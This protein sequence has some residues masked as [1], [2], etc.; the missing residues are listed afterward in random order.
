MKLRHVLTTVNVGDGDFT[1][2]VLQ[3]WNEE[4][5]MWEDVPV[6]RVAAESIDNSDYLEVR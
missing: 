6:T 5:K 4:Y 2:A 3:V 1:I